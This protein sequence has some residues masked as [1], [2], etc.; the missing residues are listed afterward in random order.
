[1]DERKEFRR[2]RRKDL[3]LLSLLSLLSSCFSRSCCSERLAPGRPRARPAPP[4]ASPPGVIR[5]S[6]E[7]E[8]GV[9]EGQ[10]RKPQPSGPPVPP[11]LLLGPIFLLGALV[12]Q[13]RSAGARRSR[14]RDKRLLTSRRGR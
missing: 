12:G 9:R 7:H 10:E 8:K 4:R 14:S 1:M 3:N 11:E 6:D 5:R 13:Y 2:I